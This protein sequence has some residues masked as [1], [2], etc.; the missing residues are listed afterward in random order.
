MPKQYVSAGRKASTP[1]D[2]VDAYGPFAS[3]EEAAEF[4]IAA[5]YGSFTTTELINPKGY[6]R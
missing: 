1:P 5:G 4:M 6:T 2:D 3:H